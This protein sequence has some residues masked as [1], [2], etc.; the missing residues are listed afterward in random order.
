MTHVP[1]LLHEVLDGLALQPGMRIVDATVGLGG[2]A[3][4]MLER[5][6]PEGTLI[7]FDRDMRNLAMTERRLDVFGDN[8]Q[9]VNESFARM[10]EFVNA[11]VDAVL[12]DLGYSSAHV[13]D[14]SRGFS[15]QN[16]GPLDMRYDLR[17]EL[18]AADIVNGWSRENMASLFRTYGEEPRSAD[19]AKAIH[20]AR[21]VDRITRTSELADIVASAI[22]SRGKTH[23]ATRIF[24]A[25]RIAV[26]NE[27]GE[28]E[29]GIYA[30]AD[31]LIPGGRMAIITFHSLEDAL[32][33]ELV[34]KR[35][36]LEKVNK[37]VI[38]P[39]YQETQR[40]RRARSA[41]LRIVKKI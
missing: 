32:V 4:A 38:K 9:L 12:F 39:Q 7:G 18:T 8:V 16:D 41:K 1:V 31:L 14:A 25:L 17:Q 26:N 11:P 10:C 23:P 21:R 15:F 40:N 3:K 30:A 20:D 35:H 28:I 13:D 22:K 34:I 33:K 29:K 37:H 2:H 27:F 5:I 6:Q 36:D 24:Q 19:V